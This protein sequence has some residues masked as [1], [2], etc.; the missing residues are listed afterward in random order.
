MERRLYDESPYI[1]E[2]QADIASV[3][4]D[5]GKFN[6]TLT[7]TAFYSGGGKDNWAH[8]GFGSVEDLYRFTVFLKDM[9]STK[10]L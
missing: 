4:S 8:G 3:E 7:E 5:G 2:L 10:A 9:L 6:V 1:T